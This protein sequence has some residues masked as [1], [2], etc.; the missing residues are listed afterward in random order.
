MPK[1][2]SGSGVENSRH[3]AKAGTQGEWVF[4]VGE[5]EEIMIDIT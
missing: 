2:V 4:L 5:V 3:R 1:T